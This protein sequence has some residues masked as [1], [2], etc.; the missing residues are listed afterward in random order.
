MVSAAVS[1]IFVPFPSA[2][3][4]SFIDLGSERRVVIMKEVINKKPRSSKV[5]LGR[6]FIYPYSL[7]VCRK[8]SYLGHMEYFL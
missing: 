6:F 7:L 5:D 1:P 3:I 4:K 2:G 8:C